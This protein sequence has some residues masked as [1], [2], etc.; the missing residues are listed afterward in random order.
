M[1]AQSV[2]LATL[3]RGKVS[4]GQRASPA[5]P[6]SEMKVDGLSVLYVVLYN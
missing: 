5:S 4:L 6:T 3:F 1:E 2:N